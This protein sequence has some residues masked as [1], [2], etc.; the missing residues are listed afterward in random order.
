MTP[1]QKLVSVQVGYN[2]SDLQVLNN[3]GVSLVNRA[4][5]RVPHHSLVRGVSVKLIPTS[6]CQKKYAR[7]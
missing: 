2:G 4:V 6:T 1:G 7:F 5:K 3:Y